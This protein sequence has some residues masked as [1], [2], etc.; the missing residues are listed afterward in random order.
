VRAAAKC[1]HLHGW[2][3]K[4]Q[5]RWHTAGHALWSR[6]C[7]SVCCCCCCC[8]GCIA[9]GNPGCRLLLPLLLLLLLLLLQ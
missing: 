4:Q 8:R 3:G 7:S 9:V 6:L 2:R 1:W 5:V